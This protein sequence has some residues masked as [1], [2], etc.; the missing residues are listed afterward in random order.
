MNKYN[1]VGGAAGQLDPGVRQYEVN[2]VISTQD[3]R[4][5]QVELAVAELTERLRPLLNN[6]EDGKGDAPQ[7]VYTCELGLRI[8]RHNERIEAVRNHIQRL[9]SRL[10]I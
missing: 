1:T 2:S 8:D 9:L 4:I 3:W 10:E 5:E 6:S 7:P